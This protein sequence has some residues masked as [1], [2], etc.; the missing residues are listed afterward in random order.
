MENQRKG[1]GKNNE[2][3]FVGKWF[4]FINTNHKKNNINVLKNIQNI[5]YRA[6]KKT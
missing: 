2:I 1:K 3:K 6:L 5:Y 4:L